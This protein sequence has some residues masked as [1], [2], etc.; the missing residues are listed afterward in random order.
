MS[1]GPQTG[2]HTAFTIFVVDD[3][4]VVR[5]SLRVFLEASHYT[6]ED[7]C[8]V[9]ALLTRVDGGNADC[10]LLD[11]RMPRMNGIEALQVLRRRGYTAPIILMTGAASHASRAQAQSMGVAL[12]EKPIPPAILVTAIEQALGRREGEPRP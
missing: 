12:L 9:E 11:I 6:V 1:S 8:S 2:P 5:E 4:E 7:F 10:V 3:D